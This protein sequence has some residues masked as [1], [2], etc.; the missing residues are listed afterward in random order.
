MEELRSFARLFCERVQNISDEITEAT[1][2][3]DSHGNGD[4]WKVQYTIMT[5]ME[6]SDVVTVLLESMQ[7]K[8]SD[9]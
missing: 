4:H 8:V 1:V 5:G 7:S 2:E 9:C 6:S 3:F